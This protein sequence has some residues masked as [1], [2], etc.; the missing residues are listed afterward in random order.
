MLLKT[1]WC[2]MLEWPFQWCKNNCSHILFFPKQLAIKSFIF[3]IHQVV[4]AVLLCIWL[5]DELIFLKELRLKKV[6]VIWSTENWTCQLAS[7][8]EELP[9]Q[10]LCS[11]LHF[12]SDRFDVGPGNM[13]T[14]TALCSRRRNSPYISHEWNK[15][16]G[17]KANDA[18]QFYSDRHGC[19]Q[20]TGVKVN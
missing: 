7:C 9:G 11:T 19:T 13:K 4:K 18:L 10:L 1:G 15:W 14:K 16:L 12:Q 3:Q 5:D 8:N 17:T 6:K 2:V 20:D